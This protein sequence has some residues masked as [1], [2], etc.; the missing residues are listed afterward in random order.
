MRATLSVFRNHK[1]WNG[2]TTTQRI[3][4]SK[5]SLESCTF[6]RTWFNPNSMWCC[7]FLVWNANCALQTKDRLF[8]SAL[9]FAQTFFPCISVACLRCWMAKGPFRTMPS[10]I[11]LS[12]QAGMRCFF[13][14]GIVSIFVVGLWSVF[15]FN[16]SYMLTTVLVFMELYCNAWITSPS[17]PS[18]LASASSSAPKGAINVQSCSPRFQCVFKY[19]FHILITV[20]TA[21][22]NGVKR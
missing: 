10:W 4:S 5:L 9:I 15:L 8:S 1:L 14:S 20:K 16:L 18:C 22:M 12:P 21:F 19:A 17:S 6:F 3:I 13:L 11:L 2:D 7:C